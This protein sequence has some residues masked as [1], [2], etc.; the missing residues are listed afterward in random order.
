MK[1]QVRIGALLS[2][3]AIALNVC[4]GLLYTPWMI[5]QIGQTQYGLYTLVNSLIALFMVDFGLSAAT[6][7]FVSEYHVQNKEEQVS[8]LL[9]AIYK[10]YIIVDAVILIALV[11]VFFSLDMIYTSLTAAEMQQF[12]I[13][14][15]IAALY[16]LI[17]FPF[18]TL[19]GILT[20]YER[21]I[22]LKVAD[23]IYRVLTIA[24]IV[25]ALANGLGLYAL[26]T[27]N[28]AVGLFVI[29]YKIVVIKTKTCVKVKF[30]RT[31]SGLYKEV[32]GF[33]VWTTVASLAQRLVFNISPTILGMVSTTSAIAVFGI[34]T[35]IESYSFTVTN[36]INGMFLSR[37]SRIY[38]G[39]ENEKTIMPLM[40]KV[41]RFQFLLNGLIVAGF[42]VL[43]KQFLGLWVG[44]DYSDAYA[45]LLLVLV[46]GLLYNP[47]QIAHTAMVVMK[48][49]NIQAK[50]NV[51]MGII[52]VCLSFLLS[53]QFGVVGA[54]VSIF[55]AYMMRAVA[56]M[57]LY[58]K[59]L[60]IDMLTFVRNCYVRHVLGILITVAIGMVFTFYCALPRWKGFIIQ[61]VVIS[62]LYLAAQY[63]TGTTAGEKKKLVE[64][65]KHG[66]TKRIG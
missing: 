10:L 56:L 28:T 46:P 11:V 58:K 43:G 18:V 22:E 23:I 20:A 55:I 6:S 47:M 35:T 54:C 3:F 1:R 40:L 63:L 49:V 36:A 26:V 27:I 14:Y 12:R 34:I 33:S 38:T 41:G 2:Y 61:A 52:N 19:N 64:K 24:L 48:K 4:A 62:A 37:I 53:K 57:V 17:S 5:E 51:A 30:V 60:G 16:S 9:G 45:G 32:L 59:H 50:V 39:K 25:L 7:R 66:I 44:A 65:I 15:C 31:E 13:I 8:S 21:F 29:L 42:A